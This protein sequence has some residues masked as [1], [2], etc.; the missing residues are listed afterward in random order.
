MMLEAYCID[1]G[2]VILTCDNPHMTFVCPN[3][4]GIIYRTEED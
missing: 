1:C 4:G 3:C 2:T